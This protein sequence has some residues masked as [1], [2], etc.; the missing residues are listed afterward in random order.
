[1]ADSMH[2]R[3][4]PRPGESRLGDEDKDM[5]I[6]VEANLSIFTIL[7]KLVDHFKRLVHKNK[8]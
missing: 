3:K 2:C 6:A 4:K 7:D 8:N 5:E 1:M